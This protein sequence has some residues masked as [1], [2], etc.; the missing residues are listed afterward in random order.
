MGA[1]RC[2]S[3]TA[4]G[5]TLLASAVAALILVGPATEASRAQAP[6]AATV[7][8]VIDA[9]TIETVFADGR[10]VTVRLIGIDTPDRGECG[11][12]QATAHMEQLALGRNVTLVSDP[13]QDAVDRFG[14]SLYYVD[15]DDGLDL[16]QEMLRAGWADVF[17]F[18]QD[19]QRLSSYRAARSEARDS[20]AGVWGRCDGDFH[21][22][23]ADE[24]RERRL[25][26][27][28]FMRRYYR[29]IS[30]RQ[31]AAAWG[32]LARPLRRKFGP[33]TAWKAGYRRSLGTSVRSAHARLSGSRAVVAVS[34]R[35]RDRD[36]CS[37]RVVRQYFRGQ[38]TLASRRDSWVAVRVRMRKT[39]GGTVR[40]SKSEC[41]PAPAPPAP[42]PPTNCQGYTPCL[43][44]GG[45]VDCRGGSGDGPRYVD[46]P[47]Y[48]RGD[49]PYDLD[50]DG[51]GVGCQS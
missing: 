39:G 47:V 35:S 22:T 31:F 6:V 37:G 44:P 17:V 26:A 19:F 9:D 12:D 34:L 51:N 46:G 49:D 33:F 16:G 38:W 28:A 18:D 7:S 50:R 43:P 29:R 15:R 13:S 48:V 1:F 25:S 30:N 24:L 21:R 42:S 27:V 3:V 40:L 8:R 20:V 23:R 10:L 2:G 5:M 45:D 41:A 4:V 11:T 36:A 14:R 32:M